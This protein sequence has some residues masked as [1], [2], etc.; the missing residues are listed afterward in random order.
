MSLQK[1]NLSGSSY[2]FLLYLTFM[3]YFLPEW[4]KLKRYPHIGLPVTMKRIR[5]V[6]SYIEDPVKVAS[7]PFLPF[8]RRTVVTYPYKLDKSTG[9]KKR[10]R[11]E[12]DLTYASHFDSLIFSYY[13][14]QL[15]KKYE[16]FVKLEHLEDVVVAYRKIKCQDGKGNKCNIHIAGDVFQYVKTS[17]R[18]GNEVALITFDIKGFFDNMDHTVL[19]RN[20]KKLIGVYDMPADVYNVFK[21]ATRFS[22]ITDEH[23]FSLFRNTI[24]CESNGQYIHRKIKGLQYMRDANSVAFCECKDM[25]VIRESGY[26]QE[27]ANGY[28][29][30]QGLP[31]SAV[32]ANIYMCDFDKDIASKLQAANGIYKRYSDDIV[33]VCPIMEAKSCQSYITEKIKNVKLEIQQEKTNLYEIRNVC[34][35]VVCFHE[36]QG[37]NKKI[38]YLGFSFD[39]VNIRIKPAGLCKYY[40]K[41]WRAK[42][43]HKHWAISINNSTNGE[44]FEHPMYKRYSRIGS[45]RHTIRKRTQ[46]GFV[47]TD[48]KTYGNYLTYVYK[49]SEVLGEI[50]IKK[51]L[52]RN[53]HKLKASIAEIYTDVKKAQEVRLNP[54]RN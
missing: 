28:G 49:A 54:S 42:K 24:L 12:R 46:G 14:D 25:R 18:K 40:N 31:I 33:V 8:V 5:A 10:K 41:M 9:V 26:L 15:Q 51:Q 38:E 23:L 17:I 1:I 20:W 22:Y 16:E 45:I 53:L 35:K 27:N 3:Q 30:P 52:R 11:K 21:H 13:A 36:T 43:R 7:H 6:R 34:G 50:G 47:K 2:T 48:K 29:I 19:K 32:L 4:F 37:T 39:G 44:I